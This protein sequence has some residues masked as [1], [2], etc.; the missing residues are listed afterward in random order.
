MYWQSRMKVKKS[1]G[2]YTPEWIETVTNVMVNAKVIPNVQEAIENILTD[3]F[4]FHV[5][6]AL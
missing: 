5:T 1:V 3:E 6:K 2:P 4:L